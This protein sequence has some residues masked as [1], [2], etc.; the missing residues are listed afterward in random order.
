MM[1]LKLCFKEQLLYYHKRHRR[2][3]FIKESSSSIYADT[4]LK[5][6]NILIFLVSIELYRYGT[7]P[8]IKYQKIKKNPNYPRKIHVL[9]G[10]SRSYGEE[11][12]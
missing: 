3:N 9:Y 5:V 6:G 7:V 1:H 8:Y 12:Q 2:V 4:G 10:K 11:I